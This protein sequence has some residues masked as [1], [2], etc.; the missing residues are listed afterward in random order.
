MAILVMPWCVCYVSARKM[1]PKSRQYIFI[2]LKIIE[3]YVMTST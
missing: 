2:V 1:G 3:Y